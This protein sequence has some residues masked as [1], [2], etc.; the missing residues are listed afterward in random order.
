MRVSSHYPTNTI[1]RTASKQAILSQNLS[2]NARRV[3]SFKSLST[4]PQ[5]ATPFNHHSFMRSGSAGK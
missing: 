3:K 2:E 4:R 1:L 5:S